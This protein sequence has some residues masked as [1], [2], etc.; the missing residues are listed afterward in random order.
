MIVHDVRQNS[1][2]WHALR[3][4]R[5]T[6]SEFAKIL[7]PTGKRSTQADGYM[8]RLLAEWVTGAPLEGIETQWM[9][10]GHDLEQQAVEGYEFFTGH[11]TRAVGFITTDDGRIG[12]SPDRLVDPA[13]GLELKCPAPQTHIAY[14]LGATVADT[15]KPQVQGCLLICEREW[16]DVFAYHPTLPPSLIRVHRDEE[17]IAKLRS[18]LD[19]FTDRL[20]EAKCELI[21]RHGVVPKP[22]AVSAKPT[23]DPL[24]FDV[25]DE[26]AAAIYAASKERR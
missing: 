21:E 4:G 3:L 19:E 11:E 18:A 5:P 14:L 12:C 23:V 15:Y 24:G 8:H 16:W 10:R 22:V 17:Y 7:S 6:A 26:D 2:E 25:T 1:V 20:E 13:G 9:E